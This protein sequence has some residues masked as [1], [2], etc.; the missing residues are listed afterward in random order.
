MTGTWLS[1]ACRAARHRRS[2]TRISY[3][4]PR[5]RTTIGWRTPE[6]RIDAVSSSRPGRNAFRG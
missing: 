6:L 3:C 1:P 5:R 4:S 2:P